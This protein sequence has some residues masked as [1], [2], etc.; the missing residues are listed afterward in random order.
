MRKN[1]PNLFI[2]G[3]AKAG[4]TS[5]YDM[6][7]SSEEVFM[8]RI[9]ELNMFS[10]DI[11]VSEF[12]EEYRDKHSNIIKNIKIK[13]G[14][15]H[16]EIFGLT[17]EEYESFFCVPQDYKYY[18]EASTSYLYSS[19]AAERIKRYNASAKII[20]CLRD[21]IDR[22]Y[23]HFKMNC[24][25]NDNR[26]ESFSEA[27][28]NDFSSENKGWGKTHLYVELS[29]YFSQVKRYFEM[30]DSENILVINFDDLKTNKLRLVNELEKFMDIKIDLSKTNHSNESVLIKNMLLSFFR[31]NEKLKPLIPKRLRSSV[32]NLFPAK[33]FPKMD[34][35][36]IPKSILNLIYLDFAMLNMYLDENKGKY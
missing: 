4:T 8:S 2:V 12:R 36:N 9:K 25:T 26:F 5:I 28:I 24:M 27:L 30:F 15:K 7:N 22:A 21:P 13:S 35:D 3:A 18:G 32:K 29:L 11:L 17:I 33:D 1:K 16:H 34:I 6:I 23:S 20:I 31:N 14:K 10:K 19:N